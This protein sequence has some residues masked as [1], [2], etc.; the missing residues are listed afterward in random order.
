MTLDHMIW[1][2]KLN[3]FKWEVHLIEQFHSQLN[4]TIQ[5][6]ADSGAT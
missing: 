5:G 1:R 3:A 4:K 2:V 6:N